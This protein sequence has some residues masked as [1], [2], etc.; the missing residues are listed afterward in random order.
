MTRTPTAAAALLGRAA[1]LGRIVLAVGGGYGVAALATA[2][3][4]LTLPL[5]RAEA[6]TTA[7][8]LSFT[9]MVV[10]VIV[11]F[12]TRTLLRALAIVGIVA[13]LLGAALWLVM[14]APPLGV[15]A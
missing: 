14:G 7:T 13:A 6:V 1:V 8:L 12:A 9:I 11:V 3:L 2:L 10:V 4:S 15:A 5:S